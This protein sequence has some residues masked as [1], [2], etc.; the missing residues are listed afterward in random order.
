MLPGRYA[1]WLKPRTPR[2]PDL[3]PGQRGSARRGQRHQNG[4]RNRHSSLVIELAAIVP[5]R[6]VR[7][8]TWSGLFLTVSDRKVS[9]PFPTETFLLA[10]SAGIAATLLLEVGGDLVMHNVR[11]RRV[12]QSAQSLTDRDPS[13]IL[14]G[15][16]PG[17][18]AGV[19]ASAT[20]NAFDAAGMPCPRR[21]MANP[22]RRPRQGV[23]RSRHSSRA[24]AQRRC[25]G[26]VPERLSECREGGITWRSRY[27]AIRG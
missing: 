27:R 20:P 21:P 1:R 24:E 11:Y 18:R 14:S 19:E 15:W 5:P 2:R 8:L 9:L 17:A 22:F 3:T 26:C 13:L 25:L 12:V 23:G 6:D 10:A 4:K 16:D 7:G